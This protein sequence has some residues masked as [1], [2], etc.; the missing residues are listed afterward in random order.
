MATIAFQFLGCRLNEAENEQYAR[1]LVQAGHRITTIDDNPD[2]I[3]LNT[4]GVTC[5]AMRKSRN[6]ARRM[7]ALAPKILVLMGC[8][9][10]L[11]DSGESPM[12][13]DEL[14]QLSKEK[15]CVDDSERIQFPDN[16]EA[17]TSLSSAK[18]LKII[19]I[20]RDERPKTAQ[21]IL[22]AIEDTLAEE[23]ID[24]AEK[25]AA[26]ASYRLRMRSFIKIQDGCNNQCTYC[27][28]RLARGRERSDETS[29]IISEINRCLAL[30]ER[31]IVL[32]GVQLGAWR[33]NERRLHNLIED[34][35]E[36]TPV[37]RLRISSIEPWHVR[38]E[39]WKLW[40]DKRLCP[41]FHIP[42]QSGSDGV[43]TAMKRRTPIDGYLEKIDAIRALIP[44]VRIST[45]LIVGFPGET[46]E[47]WLETM[48]FIR[49]AQFDEAH[50]F[51]FSPRP[52]TVA[53]SLPNPVP[54][55]I[56]K[57]R[58][59]EAEQLIQS[60][61]KSR[62]QNTIG[63][64]HHVLWETQTTDAQNNVKWT[65]YSENYLR[66][67]RSNPHITR[68]DITEVTFLEEDIAGNLI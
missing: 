43:L 21:I 55:D 26:A 5:D 1:V 57:R 15:Q 49:R 60:L 45:D 37:Q 61:Q 59:N 35:L 44:N 54:A 50:L 62:L 48:D 12:T 20:L 25:K 24:E 11:M 66:F 51:R 17:E 28:V 39:L 9:I 2:V 53:A 46:D 56:K 36:Q 41:H 52:N 38:P 8:A 67:E 58:W 64:K 47:M 65:G 22:N 63:S 27:A 29:K 33:E 10:D 13:D 19:R 14:I 6:Y 18:P 4:C 23:I 68:G 32:T 40:L 31:E 16:D 34:I 30:G 7:A 3:V 42:V